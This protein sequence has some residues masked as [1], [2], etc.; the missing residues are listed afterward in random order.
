MLRVDDLEVR[1][2]RAVALR[3]VSLEVQAGEFVSIVGPNGAGKSSLLLAIAGVL[4]PAS[5]RITFAG[6]TVA[7]VRPERLVKRGLAL[8]PEG[9]HIFASL[10]VKENL[11]L[12][13]TVRKDKSAI[14]KD[15]E[16]VFEL[17]PVLRKYESTQAAKLSGGEQQMLAIGR[18]LLSRP[19]LLMLDEPSLGL[20][21]LVVDLVFNALND[22][23][24][25]GTTVLLVEQNAVRAAEI[26]DRTY[27]LK[28][29][30]VTLTATRQELMGEEA[31]QA[32]MLGL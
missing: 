7:G 9:R 16:R 26:A 4:Q 18:A 20:A 28:N 30:R 14:V 6:E 13:A 3:M 5:G 8:V 27:V 2:G 22:L 11:A 10:S 24:N 19:R 12:G 23:K 1:Y 32:E 31:L 15:K 17:F 21:P 25:S 29:G